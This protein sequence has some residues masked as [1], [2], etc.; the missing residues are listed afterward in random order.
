MYLLSKCISPNKIFYAIALSILD[1]TR[2]C[3][4]CQVFSFSLLK[5]LTAHC[6]N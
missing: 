2:F 5:R 3:I 6:V 4:T 1:N